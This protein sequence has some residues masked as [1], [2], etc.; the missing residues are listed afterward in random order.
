MFCVGRG[1]TINTKVLAAQGEH[2]KTPCVKQIHAL[3]YKDVTVLWMFH[4]W[5][6]ITVN[7]DDQSGQIKHNKTITFLQEIDLILLTHN[8][9]SC[10]LCAAK[11]SLFTVLPHPTQN[12]EITIPLLH[13]I[14][15][16]CIKV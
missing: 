7:T 3:F 12:I 14:M 2:E 4:A 8:V 6:R 13:K 15:Y 10:F 16:F 5:C 1:S 11:M 9:F